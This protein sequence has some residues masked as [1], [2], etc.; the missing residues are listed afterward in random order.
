MELFLHSVLADQRFH[1]LTQV[2][3]HGCPSRLEIVEVP[4]MR[5]KSPQHRNQKLYHKRNQKRHG[6]RHVQGQKPDHHIHDKI[7]NDQCQRLAV[8]NLRNRTDRNMERVIGSAESVVKD[9]KQQDHDPVAPAI[10][11]YLCPCGIISIP[12]KAKRYHHENQI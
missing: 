3:D 2:I 4:L 5:Q 6:I 8:N 1:A 10:I 12:Y 7:G 11:M 9:S